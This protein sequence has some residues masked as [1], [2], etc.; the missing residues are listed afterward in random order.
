MIFSY[1]WLQRFFDKDVLPEPEKIFEAL[2]LYSFEVEDFKKLEDDFIFDVDILPNRAHDC[3]AHRGLAK[4]LGVIFDLNLKLENEEDFNLF[5]KNSIAINVE[6]SE[7]CRSYL[8]V[9]MDNIEVKDSPDWLKNLL[10]N[11]GARPINNLVD[12]MNFVMFDIGQ[13][14]HVFDADLVKGN[15]NIRLASQGE[16]MTTLDGEDLELLDKHLIIADD[17]GPLALAGVKGGDRAGV[18]K[19]TKRIIIEAANFSPV[20]IRKTANYF[21]LRT[22][23]AKRF[24]NDLPLI[25]ASKSI[26]EA[27]NL[28]KETIPKAEIKSSFIWQKEKKEKKKITMALNLPSE[29]LGTRIEKKEI[30][31]ILK[32]LE[33]DF[34]F[35]DDKWEMTMPLERLDLE[36]TEDIIEEVGRLYGY[37]NVKGVLPDKKDSPPDIDNIFSLS[38][39][40]KGEMVL[41]GFSELYGYTFK[42]EGEEELAN[43][44]S[45]DKRFLRTDL[46]SELREKLLFNLEHLIFD[47]QAVRLFEIGAVFKNKEEKI[48]FAY[49]VAWRK[50][51]YARVDEE[52]RL[53]KEKIKK[54]LNLNSEPEEIVI[55][56]GNLFMVEIDLEELLTL[57]SDFSSVD[58][59]TLKDK[60][61]KYKSFSVYPRIIRD[62]ALFV[63][64]NIDHRQLSEKIIEKAGPFLIKEPI[65]FD[66]FIKDGKKS[67]A[68]RLIFQAPDKTLSNEEINDQMEQIYSRLKEEN[69]QIR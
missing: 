41:L 58:L 44:L 56:D 21:N 64:E 62:V 3:L 27:I 63:D 42:S 33:I 22:D 39:K 13:P 40:L 11:I 52:L 59:S 60:D 20:N 67:L 68:F 4:E 10:L 51:K 53:I 38:N 16:K 6:D 24:E 35:I 36:I 31:D 61:I 32:K 69:W 55:K 26:G 15:I 47:W 50:N 48:K 23:A 25:F 43:P 2:N 12:I 66:E 57:S 1:N 18:N 8:A 29:I 49:G 34:T 14:L 54:F 30:E 9:E 65:L 28:I 46:T 19:K 37:N 45:T 17:L 5:K 7:N